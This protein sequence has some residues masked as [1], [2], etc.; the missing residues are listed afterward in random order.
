MNNPLYF[1][2][3]TFKNSFD[4][5]FFT[6]D[7]ISVIYHKTKKYPKYPLYIVGYF[8]I[9]TFSYDFFNLL[10]FMKIRRPIETR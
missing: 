5:H 7:V 6:R 2:L 1:V 8:F 9:G 10:F 3:P 4:F